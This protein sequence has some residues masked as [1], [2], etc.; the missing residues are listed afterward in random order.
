MNKYYKK[1]E[2][3]HLIPLMLMIFMVPLIVRLK[4]IPLTGARF[5][6]WTGGS[7]VSDFFS[8]Y[9]MIWILGCTGLSIIMLLVKGYQEQFKIFKKSYYFIPIAVYS[10]A[11]ILSTLLS[12]YKDIATWGFVDRYEGMFILLAYMAI[13]VVTMLL[14]DSEYHVKFMFVILIFSAIIIG[15]IGIF[16]YI[17][18]DVFQTNFG[19]SFILPSEFMKFADQV[20]FKFGKN[21]I[22]STLYHYNYV[23]SYMAMLFP[24]TLTMFILIKNKIV[25]VFMGIVTIL[26]AANWIACS[27]RAGIIGGGLA[28]IIL[29]IMMRKNVKEKKKYVGIAAVALIVVFVSLNLISKG[30][31]SSRIK[32]LSSEMKTAIVSDKKKE[33]F[34]NLIPL[35]DVKT[36][37]NTAYININ[38][39]VLNIEMREAD[40]AFFDGSNENI[41]IEHKSDTGKIILNDERYKSYDIGLI[42]I[43]DENILEIKKDN[44]KLYFELKSKY[45]G[46]V[47]F[48]GKSIDI[49]NIESFGFEGKEKLASSRG[50]IW[51]RSLPLL[52]DKL[53]LGHGPD[54]FA[55]YFPQQDIK[56]KMYAYNGDMWQLVDKPH[57]LYLQTALNTGVVSLIAMLALFIMY[58]IKSFK[59]YY[60]S[61]FKDFYSIAGLGIFVAVVGYLGA[62]I[63][64]DSVV[65]VAPVFWVLLG[66]GISINKILTHKKKTK[67]STK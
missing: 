53:L 22:Y 31:L 4:D 8:Y 1:D 6:L 12:E 23:G 18:L 62:G 21:V 37:G 59:I 14:V 49:D 30:A 33:D 67:I 17:G 10:V 28:L 61:D 24:L 34:K 26:M 39:Q 43:N 5:D 40:M 51:S 20:E 41:N 25:K 38:N 50:Y 2:A 27:S 15:T 35:K 65:S 47:D 7:K 52:K 16:Q 45:I 64:N 55:A 56:G 13:L 42:N 54:T 57:N 29:L 36:K 9:K 46:I 66:M 3:Y 32:T 48:K 19:K 63:F 60:N 11:V 58:F 44:I